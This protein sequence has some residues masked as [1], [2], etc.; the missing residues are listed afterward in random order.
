MTNATRSAYYLPQQLCHTI[1]L[2]TSCGVSPNNDAVPCTLLYLV[3]QIPTPDPP[4][5]LTS[6]RGPSLAEKR[7]YNAHPNTNPMATFNTVPDADRRPP[8]RD[9]PTEWPSFAWCRTGASLALV[10]RRMGSVVPSTDGFAT[11]E[12]D[13]ELHHSTVWEENNSSIGCGTK[14]C[15]FARSI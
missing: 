15:P 12:P 13:N 10:L 5:T 3:V 2:T 9:S 1:Y 14:H 6:R 7:A 8:L 4:P 11:D